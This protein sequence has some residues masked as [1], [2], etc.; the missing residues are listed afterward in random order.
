MV[1]DL[2]FGESGERQPQSAGAQA[3][4][5]EKEKPSIYTYAYVAKGTGGFY[6]F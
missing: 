4:G 5:R 6:I 1:G 2:G 3:R